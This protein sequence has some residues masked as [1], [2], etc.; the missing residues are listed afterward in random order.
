MLAFGSY[1]DQVFQYLILRAVWQLA[2]Y[3]I[4]KRVFVLRDLQQLVQ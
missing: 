3:L 1:G 4:V 2:K